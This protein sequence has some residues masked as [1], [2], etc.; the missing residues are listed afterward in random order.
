V[1]INAIATNESKT[2]LP[3]NFSFLINSRLANASIGSI[4]NSALKK[5]TFPKIF[6]G[7]L[8]C[9][10]DMEFSNFA[11]LKKP[12]ESLETYCDE[13]FVTGLL[14]EITKGNIQ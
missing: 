14:A 8:A 10:N 3:D 4:K 11:K 6:S 13:R 7:Q 5:L 2:L 12:K 9:S 1:P